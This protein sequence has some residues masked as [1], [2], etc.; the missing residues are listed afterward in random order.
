[1]SRALI[2]A[3]T[4]ALTT[5]CFGQFFGR[6]PKATGAGVEPLGR[7]FARVRTPEQVVVVGV[8]EYGWEFGMVGPLLPLIPLVPITNPLPG[9]SVTLAFEKESAS[10]R[11]DPESVR[12][13]IKGEEYAPRSY[14]VAP[15]GEPPL[16]KRW[17]SYDF[18][19]LRPPRTFTLLIGDLPPTEFESDWQWELRYFGI[20]GI[21]SR[22]TVIAHVD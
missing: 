21:L 3:L 9:L 6:Y 20:E 5:G 10:G 11:F 17:I 2:A 15:P 22:G 14:Y 16:D 12:V 19:Q 18:G 1:V 13:R 4:C 7:S 8:Y